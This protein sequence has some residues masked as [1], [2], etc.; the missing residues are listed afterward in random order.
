[1]NKIS[2]SQNAEKS[3][4]EI[5]RDLRK[6]FEKGLSDKE[7]DKIQLNDIMLAVLVIM[8]AAISFTDFS[9]SFGTL[10]NFTA[11]T[12]FLFVITSLVY[13]NRYA[14]GMQK[15]KLDEDYLTSLEE[16]RKKRK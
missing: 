4:A 14:R 7:P 11:L 13:R 5:R 10:K 3:N 12:L 6:N 16:Y 2:T 8:A 9:L 1:M 15:G